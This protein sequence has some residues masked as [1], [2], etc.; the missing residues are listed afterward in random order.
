MLQRLSAVRTY[1]HVYICPHTI[2]TQYVHTYCIYV[3]MPPYNMHTICTYIR[4]IYMYASMQYAHNMYIHTF[5][6]YAS[7][8]YAHNMYIHTVRTVCMPPY[9]IMHT[10]IQC[11]HNVLSIPHVI[12]YTY[13]Y[14]HT[15]LCTQYSHV[16]SSIQFGGVYASVQ[17][18][19]VI[20]HTHMQYMGIFQCTTSPVCQIATCPPVLGQISSM[21]HTYIHP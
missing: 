13:V 11:V 16:Y 8:Q 17:Y 10:S 1:T 5:C 19:I 6:M 12:Y 18:I 7:I 9:N 3:C 4:T 21:M 14:L 15:V 2:C 20:P